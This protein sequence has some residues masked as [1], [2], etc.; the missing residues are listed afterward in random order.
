MG[1]NLPV[2]YPQ[3]WREVDAYDYIYTVDVCL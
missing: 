1:E 2:E 3:S